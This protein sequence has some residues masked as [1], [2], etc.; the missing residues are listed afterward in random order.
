MLT[1]SPSNLRL[2]LLFFYF[3]MYIGGRNLLLR[4]YSK[5]SSHKIQVQ[6]VKLQSSLQN[7]FVQ[8]CNQTAWKQ[9]LLGHKMVQCIK[10]LLTNNILGDKDSLRWWKRSLILN[11]GQYWNKNDQRHQKTSDGWNMLWKKKITVSCTTAVHQA[12]LLNK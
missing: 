11:T 7:R 4:T 2:I 1:W 8:Y 9:Y 10:T 6:N 3:H 12:F 5:R